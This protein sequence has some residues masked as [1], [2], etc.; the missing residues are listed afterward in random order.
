MRY[1]FAALLISI[2]TPLESYFYWYRFTREG[3]DIYIAGAA[4]AGLILLLS[5]FV[6]LARD[7]RKLYA[8]ALAVALFSVVSTSAGQS[9]ATLSEQQLSA[10][11]EVRVQSAQDMKTSAEEEVQRLDA[12]YAALTRQIDATVSSLEDRYA[13]QRTLATVDAQRKTNRDRRESELRRFDQAVLDL[14]TL[15]VSRQTD[16]YSYYSSLFGLSARWL[17]FI[18]HTILS[19]F[20]TAMTPTGVALWPK[21][22]LSLSPVLINKNEVNITE[23]L[24]ALPDTVSARQAGA[25]LGVSHVPLYYAMHRGEL[26]TCSIHPI[27]FSRDDVAAWYAGKKEQLDARS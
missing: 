19:A 12:D 20:L 27:R 1:I 10:G 15:S 25:A 26:K 6:Y 23:A 2:G 3:M 13:W 21:K 8:P 5:V 18:L 16:I 24:R 7:N 11:V 9:F 22:K 4:G 14:A 17:Q